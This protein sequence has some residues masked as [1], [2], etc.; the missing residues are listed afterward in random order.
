MLANEKAPF[1]AVVIPCFRVKKH[2]LKV[3]SEIG[4]DV[5]LIFVVDDKCPEKTGKFVEAETGD[6]R[7]KV[8]F[9]EAN[10]GV[11]GAT[12]T[13]Y[14]EAVAEGAE[15]I[16]KIDGDGQMKPTL[17]PR[18]IRPILAG[19]ADYTKGNRFFH[20][21]KIQQMPTA[22]VVGN[23]L[24]SFISKLSTGYWDIFDPTNG[25]TAI[26]ARVVEELPF[27]KISKR[28][29][30][31]SDML[32]R[33]NTL[34][35]VVVDIP[36]HARYGDEESNLNISKIIGEFA[37]KHLANFFK[38]I[39]YTYYLRNFNIASIEI[40]LGLVLLIFGIVVGSDRWYVSVRTGIPATSGTVMLAALPMIIGMQLVLA[41][42]TYDMQN[43]PNR[44]LHK[45]L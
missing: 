13:G 10:Q 23:S 11:G 38:R 18:F 27:D 6:I 12:I 39:F 5:H 26:H 19:E 44:T 22:R 21:D 8:I 34:R 32:F 14:R 37:G 3:L 45:R 28:Y 36:M 2:I 16:V 35:A 17:I 33:L 7:V 15:I 4:S 24:L 40:I 20:L 1:V 29:F 30:F 43:V 31:E 9:H 42:M 25:F 41:F